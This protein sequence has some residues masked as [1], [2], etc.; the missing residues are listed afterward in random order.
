MDRCGIARTG[1]DRRLYRG[2]CGHSHRHAPEPPDASPWRP[3]AGPPGSAAL[4]DH[5]GREAPKLVEDLV[6]KTRQPT[7]VAESIAGPAG[8]G[9]AYTRHAH[10]RRDNGR[11][12]APPGGACNAS[13]T[14]PDPAELLAFTRVA[15]GRAITQQWFP[16]DVEVRVIGLEARLE[17]V[18]TQ[19]LSTSGALEP[20]LA[21][22]VLNDAQRAVQVQR[23]TATLRYWLCRRYCGL[24]CRAFCAIMSRRSACSPT[25]RYPMNAPCA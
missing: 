6:P 14:G 23:P 1:P 7:L 20:G 2:R 11:A 12:S 25:P 24:R 13:G 15:L 22:S 4:L 17:R 9:S 21:E 19:A 16:G 10:D 5:V 3:I 18:L 8:R